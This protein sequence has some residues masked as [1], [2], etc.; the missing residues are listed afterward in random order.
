MRIVLVATVLALTAC[1]GGHRVSAPACTLRLAQGPSPETGEHPVTVATSCAADHAP[2]VE[3]FG[4]HG[5]RLPF[6]YIQEGGPKGAHTILLDKYRCD[7]RSVDLG[8]TVALGSARLDVGRS[9]LDWCPAEAI[10]TVVHVYLGG[11]HPHAT[12]RGVL[13]DVYDGRLDRVWPCAA[14]RSAIKHLPVD[15]PT[16]SAIPGRLARAAA[17]ACDAQLGEIE[18]G[19][20]RSAVD[21]ALGAPD[22]GGPRCPVWRWNPENGS[23]DGARVCFAR[24]RATL[25]QSAVHG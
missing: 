21:E 20:P 1:G 12:W 7:V 19:A 14:L 16:Y 17:P 22:L 11:R 13:R 6:T 9:L 25:V 10:S 18:V 24:G 23:V 5:T 15:G 8:H 4:L 3:I 2:H